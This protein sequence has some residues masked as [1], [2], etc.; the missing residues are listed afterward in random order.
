MVDVAESA[1]RHE[2]FREGCAYG[3]WVELSDLGGWQ[4][5]GG[6]RSVGRFDAGS[7]G[8]EHRG[9]VRGRRKHQ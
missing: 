8:R 2:R 5:D 4:E 1:E 6:E 3:V 9:A 7:E